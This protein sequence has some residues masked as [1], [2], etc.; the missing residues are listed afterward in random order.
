M[1]DGFIARQIL[2]I[3]RFRPEVHLA[4]L[5]FVLIILGFRAFLDK[6]VVNLIFCW[7]MGG[8]VVIFGAG[9]ILATRKDTERRPGWLS[10]SEEM[11][12]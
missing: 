2:N 11:E 3:F 12:R 8:F 6:D 7:G 9:L 4:T 10:E 5:H 1:K